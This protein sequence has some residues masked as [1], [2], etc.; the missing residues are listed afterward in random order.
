MQIQVYKY[1]KTDRTG[2][3]KPHRCDAAFL[4][5]SIK[6]VSDVW[7][8]TGYKIGVEKGDSYICGVRSTNARRSV[9]HKDAKN[10]ETFHLT[11]KK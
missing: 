3:K 6:K 4:L 2:C 10:I 11:G 8:D 1:S 7:G 5:Q 9:I